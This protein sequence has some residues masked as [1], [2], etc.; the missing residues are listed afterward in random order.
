M[1][2]E[3]FDQLAYAR[4]IRSAGRAIHIPVDDGEVR[5]I[6]SYALRVYQTGAIIESTAFDFGVPAL[7]SQSISS[8]L[9]GYRG[10]LFPISSSSYRGSTLKSN[11]SKI[12]K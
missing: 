6:P 11:G 9:R 4:R 8:S 7:D 3:G 5:Y 1:K 2:N 10:S 12:P